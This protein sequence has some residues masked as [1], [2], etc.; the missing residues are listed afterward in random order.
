MLAREVEERLE[1]R[2]VETCLRRHAPHM[3]DDE[4]HRELMQK[5]IE[6]DQVASIEV[7]INVPAQWF[8]T[9]QDA[10]ELAHVRHTAQVLH[11]VEAHTAEALLMQLLEVSPG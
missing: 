6:L 4:R 8:D 5:V 9:L 7:Q 2:L 3:V 11:E 1:R 10:V